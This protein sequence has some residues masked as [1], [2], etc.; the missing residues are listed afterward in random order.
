MLP[1]S[2]NTILHTS[3]LLTSCLSALREHNVLKKRKAYSTSQPN[4][5]WPLHNSFL[6]P[7][8]HLTSTNDQTAT[9]ST[10]AAPKIPSRP[11]KQPAKHI[12]PAQQAAKKEDSRDFDNQAP[13]RTKKEQKIS[14]YAAT[15]HTGNTSSSNPPSPPRPPSPPANSPNRPPQRVASQTNSDPALASLDEKYLS[16]TE[17]TCQL[18]VKVANATEQD[19]WQVIG[20]TKDVFI[21][22]KPPPKGAPPYNCVKGTGMVRAPPEFVLRFLKNPTNTQQLDDLLK[23]SKIFHEVS[24]AIHI[25]QLLYK[26]VWPTSPREFSVM[27]VSGQVDEHTWVQAGLSVQ[28]PR[29]PEAK[30]YVRGDLVVGGYVIRSISGKPELSEVT[31]AVQADMKGSLPSFAVNKITESQP[32]CVSR[33]RNLVEPFYNSVKKDPQ[34]LRELEET[35]E[36]VQILPGIRQQNSPPL[37]PELQDQTVSPTPVPDDSSPKSFP[38]SSSVSG[39]Q[40]APEAVELEGGGG[41]R[42]EG[43][44]QDKQDSKLGKDPNTLGVFDEVGLEEDFRK[45][46]SGFETPELVEETE[47]ATLDVVPGSEQQPIS[48]H[49]ES[50]TGTRPASDGQDGSA[51]CLD[52]GGLI[53]METLETYTPLELSSAQESEEEGQE[54]VGEGEMAGDKQGGG[55]AD[56]Q[57][58]GEE[59]EEEG[60][61]ERGKEA[62]RNGERNGERKGEEQVRSE[63]RGEGEEVEVGVEEEEEVFI[64]KRGPSLELKLPPYPREATRE[65]AEDSESVR[66]PWYSS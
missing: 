37:E 5:Q 54:E 34:K 61:A 7:N 11:A 39:E 32:Q 45:D 6:L 50:T 51:T 64:M 2:K 52:E 27:S 55:G 42:V 30:G 18:L 47:N 26:A 59:K 12:K 43:A 56:E 21:M 1:R 63:G 4:N 36:I 48:M 58:G 23:E 60:K 62:G 66:Y 14:S 31:Y 19:G 49:F 35:Y 13:K 33:L 29:I 57:G 41:G 25:V 16:L 8:L 17:Q 38:S 9:I 65:D 22:K 53:I 20:T 24:S 44:W 28:D 46:S 40:I 10:T 3:S 15:Q